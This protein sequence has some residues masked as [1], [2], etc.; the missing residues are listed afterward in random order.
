MHSFIHYILSI[1]YMFSIFHLYL[2]V[3]WPHLLQM[4]TLN[5]KDHFCPFGW[6]SML[7]PLATHKGGQLLCLYFANKVVL[8]LESGPERARKALIYKWI[9]TLCSKQVI[10]NWLDAAVSTWCSSALTSRWFTRISN[11]SSRWYSCVDLYLTN[12]SYFGERKIDIVNLTLGMET[13]HGREQSEKIRALIL[14]DFVGEIWK[15]GN[16]HKVKRIPA[17]HLIRSQ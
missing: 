14:S 5:C 13:L 4:H 6:I 1:L 11:D 8:F 7:C 16:W 2:Y 12:T 9:N 15:R 17:N 3:Y 10:W